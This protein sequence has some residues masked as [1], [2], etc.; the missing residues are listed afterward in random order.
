MQ[1]VILK[2][3][4]SQGYITI[5]QFIQNSL[6]SFTNSYYRVGRR[7]GKAG[8]FITAPEVS[9]LFGEIIA[10]YFIDIWHKIGSPDNFN[11]VEL[12]PGNGTLM[13]DLL[14]IFKKYSKVFNA[15][16]IC[17]VEINSS[18]KDEQKIILS[19]YLDKIQ[20][21]TKLEDLNQ[22]P[23]IIIA[24]EFFDCLP[25]KQFIKYDQL[26][27]R[28]IKYCAAENNFYYDYI[29]N[30][31]SHRLSALHQNIKK[32]SILEISPVREKIM[33]SLVKLIGLNT[34]SILVIDY[35][36]N[37]HPRQRC[38]NHYKDTL[39]AIK[40]HQYTNIFENIG[41]SDLSSHVDFSSLQNVSNNYNVKIDK[42]ITQN[43]FL[44][45]CGIDIRVKNIMKKNS[46]ALQNKDLLKQ[47]QYLM[48]NSYLGNF[49]VLMISKL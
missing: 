41:A 39:Q 16:N 2:V 4:K 40:R 8:D 43:E 45:R 6:S 10:A 1:S 38:T 13:L 17:L 30:N 25:I 21:F 19:D 15:M 32:N 5:D 23:S 22:K 27:E 26:Y 36:Y 7:L 31:E 47:Y 44:Y 14:R 9:F 18:L 20:W 12:G 37:I 35:G 48:S 33:E 46:N 34:G 49:K 42:V 29:E 11:L 24:N 28:V 3:I